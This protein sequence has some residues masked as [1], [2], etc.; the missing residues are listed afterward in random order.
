MNETSQITGQNSIDLF[1]ERHAIFTLEELHA[2]LDLQYSSNSKTRKALLTYH[3]Q[4]G[5]ILAIRRGLYATVPKKS[6]GRQ[7][8][9]EPLLM[10]A[11]LANGAI[12]SHHT[13]LQA[14]G[15]AYSLSSSIVY[16]A[17][18]RVESLTFQGIS[19]QRVPTPKNLLLTG[20]QQIGTVVLQLDGGDVVVTGYERSLVDC[21]Q[22]IYLCG[23]FEE[24]W[25]SLSSIEFF[26]LDL[27]LAYLSLLQNATTTAKVGFFLEQHKSR[28]LVTDSFLQEL[29]KQKPKNPHYM[30]RR[31][32]R[33]CV[34]QK[35]WNL[36]VPKEVIHQSWEEFT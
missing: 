15:T 3:K 21:L 8:R 16:T 20:N 12:L 9:V 7:F 2:F 22:N 34:L 30:D 6:I 23:G 31:N 19:Y 36:M 11:K 13:A 1:F 24:V 25:R 5:R 14:L 33:D 26:D 28:L 29:R 27:V 18:P 10:P 17:E 35:Q 4:R 32:R